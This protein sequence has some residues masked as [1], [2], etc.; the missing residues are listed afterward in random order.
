LSN[1]FRTILS[2]AIFPF[3]RGGLAYQ[4]DVPD[5]E[6]DSSTWI[7]TH[8]VTAE[9]ETRL[10]GFQVGGKLAMLY[11]P[12]PG[13]TVV[14][15]SPGNPTATS[16]SVRYRSDFLYGVNASYACRFV[17]VGAALLTNRDLDSS[18]SWSVVSSV[19]AR[20][21]D[22][23]SLELQWILDRYSSSAGAPYAGHYGHIVWA[24]A[25]YEILRGVTLGAGAKYVNNPGPTSVSNASARRE[26]SLLLSLQYQTGLF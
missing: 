11:D 10:G 3:L 12:D 5:F 17:D 4:L 8:K 20:P 1:E 6:Y 22:P 25:R 2:L 26:F 14:A 9:A 24:E 21:I 23:L 15:H 18:Y 19:T 13:K 7:A 16:T